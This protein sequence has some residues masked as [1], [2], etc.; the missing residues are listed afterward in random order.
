MKRLPLY[1]LV[2]PLLIAGMVIGCVG[3]MLRGCWH[4]LNLGW[5]IP[6]IMELRRKAKSRNQDGPG[7]YHHH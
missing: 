6:E 1:A 2:S 5:S 7:G 4:S 3:L